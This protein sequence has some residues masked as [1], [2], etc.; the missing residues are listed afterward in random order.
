MKTR[1]KEKRS[2]V[3]VKNEIKAIVA[4]MINSIENTF[5]EDAL[6]KMIED[7]KLTT[8]NF[9]SIFQTNFIN[10][11]LFNRLELD[12]KSQLNNKIA[13]S[14]EFLEETIPV[15]TITDEKEKIIIRYLHSEF[16]FDAEAD[17]DEKNE[18][19][20]YLDIIYD[21]SCN[22]T[23]VA[24]SPNTLRLVSLG[25]RDVEVTPETE[26]IAKQYLENDFVKIGITWVDVLKEV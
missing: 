3:M 4:T 2:H 18:E 22:C 5:E 26:E 7:C 11:D 21:N 25:L 6:G 12:R 8:S 20:T 19:F 15:F 17:E 9:K 14:S 10:T 23:C 24:D 16:P 13:W 1:I